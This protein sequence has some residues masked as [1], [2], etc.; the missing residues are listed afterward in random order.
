MRT[1]GTLRNRGGQ[2]MVHTMSGPCC[3]LYLR[4]SPVT[5]ACSFGGPPARGAE[6]SLQQGERP[7]IETP[8]QSHVPERSAVACAFGGSAGE[9][10]PD[11]G[12]VTTSRRPD[13][14]ASAITPAHR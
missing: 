4:D 1:R 11:G 3:P 5:R 9:L 14:V 6:A 8:C 10:S 13:R 7:T 12:I 2:T